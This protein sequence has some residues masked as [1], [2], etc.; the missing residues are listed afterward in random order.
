[1]DF[2]QEFFPGMRLAAHAKTDFPLTQQAAPGLLPHLLPGDRNP[3]LTENV[4]VHQAAQRVGRFD[5]ATVLQ[6]QP[7][8]K[9][10]QPLSLIDCRQGPDPD[11]AE[12]AA[13]TVQQRSQSGAADQ[14]RIGTAFDLPGELDCQADQ[15][16]ARI[17]GEQFALQRR[18][19]IPASEKLFQR[20]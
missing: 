7:L 14:Q 19:F 15:A 1:M 6:D 9:A 3:V 10:Q 4:H 8:G 16:A 17:G 20:H 13:E 2:P 5:C 18:P 11:M 12:D